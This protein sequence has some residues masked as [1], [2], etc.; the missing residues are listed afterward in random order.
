MLKL[1][2]IKKK[3]NYIDLYYNKLLECNIT[4]TDQY[5]HFK[6]SEKELK[7]NWED[8]KQYIFY[9]GCLFLSLK[10]EEKNYEY[11]IDLSSLDENSKAQIKRRLNKKN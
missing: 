8:F 10:N 1:K 9:K 6:T 7:H 4:F 3:N 11:L 5:I 2:E